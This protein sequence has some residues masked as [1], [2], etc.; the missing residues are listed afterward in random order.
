MSRNFLEKLFKR[1]YKQKQA[2]YLS[3]KIY[4]QKRFSFLRQC[5]KIW[6]SQART[7]YSKIWQLLFACFRWGYRHTLR[8]CNSYCFPTSSM[9]KQSHCNV[10]IIAYYLSC[11]AFAFANRAFGVIFHTQTTN[12]HIK[13]KCFNQTDSTPDII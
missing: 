9:V 3:S 7:T 6:Y 11:F 12:A 13:K 5:G 8:M 10:T 2:R 1:N 4:F